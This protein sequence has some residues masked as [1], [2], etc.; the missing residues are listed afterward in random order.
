MR[1]L[2]IPREFALFLFNVL[3]V[4]LCLLPASAFAQTAA[5]TT[6]DYTSIVVWILGVIIAV[7]VAIGLAIFSWVQWLAKK[8]LGITI[9]AGYRKTIAD[10]LT[11]KGNEI[12][13]AVLNAHQF[14]LDVKNPIIAA[15]GNDAIQRVPDAL[16]H[17]SVTPAT[18]ADWVAKRLVGVLGGMPMFA[19]LPDVPT[20]VAPGVVSGTVPVQPAPGGVT[21]IPPV[22]APAV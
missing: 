20:L 15:A 14:E 11:N 18:V 4:T 13:A 19:N 2:R 3:L 8:S 5:T 21:M 7:L 1:L 22:L 16:A 10:Y 17:F 9:D 6:V 12:G